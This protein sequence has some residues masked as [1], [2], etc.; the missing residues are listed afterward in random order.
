MGGKEKTKKT[1]RAYILLDESTQEAK[2]NEE[3][4]EASSN[5]SVGSGGMSFETSKSFFK[6]KT[7]IQKEFGKTWTTK[8]DTGTPGKVVDHSLDVNKIRGPIGDLLSQNKWK[9]VLVTS[10]KD[11]SYKKKGLVG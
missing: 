11:A 1:Y 2:Y 3:I 4:T 6:G 7:F 9:L 8:K 5:L 10:R